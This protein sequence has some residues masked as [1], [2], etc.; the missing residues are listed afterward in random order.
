MTPAWIWNVMGGY[1][2]PNQANIAAPNLTRPLLC[3]VVI[4]DS[5]Q[6]LQPK[7]NKY[8]SES[9]KEVHTTLIYTALSDQYTH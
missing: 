1:Q 7:S 8:A 5:D 3:A 6:D 4:L 2:V 9:G